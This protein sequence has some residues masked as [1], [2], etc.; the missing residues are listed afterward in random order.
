MEHGIKQETI[1]SLLNIDQSTV[2]RQETGHAQPTME[3][4]IKLAEFYK[5]TIDDIIS[6]EG[7]IFHFENNQVNNAGNINNYFE[8]QQELLK[9]TILI[10]RDLS[11]QMITLNHRYLDILESKKTVQ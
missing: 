1:A 5:T 11:N 9:D 7:H 4:A 3:Q 8:N 2:S 10:L 6:N